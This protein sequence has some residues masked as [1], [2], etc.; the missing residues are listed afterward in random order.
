VRDYL[1]KN[2]GVP[3]MVRSDP[4]EWRIKFSDST[5]TYYK[6]GTLYSTPSNSADP[7]VL[8][9]WEYVDS[10]VG[11]RYALPTKDFLIGLDETGKGE[12][13]GHTVLTG[14]IFPK[15]IFHQV[16]FVVGS[17]DTKSRHEYNYWDSLFK[18]LDQFRSK[19]LDFITDKVAPWHVDKFNINKIM[20]VTYQ[21]ILSAFYRESQINRCRVVL[22]DYGVGQTLRR[23]LNFLGKQ[24][25]EII[26]TNRSDEKYLEA[27]TASLI[28]KW[29]RESVMKAISDNLEFK[30][31]ELSV[32]SGNAGD[33][34]TLEWLHR[35][36]QSGKEW[37]W[38][39][40][41]SFRT[42]REIEGKSGEIQKIA[43]PI[44]EE[45]L[46]REFITE[47]D[48]G[49]FSMQ[50]LSIVCPLCGQLSKAV[51]YAVSKVKC[52]SCHK[53]I[54]DVGVTLRYYCG[55]IVP[56]TNI[57]L[58]GL[59]SKDL[60]EGKFFEN[61]TVIIPPIVRKECETRGGRKECDRLAKFASMG[62]IKLEEPGTISE[63]PDGLSTIERDERIVD[64]VF[65]QNAILLTADNNM[66]ARAIA[67][68]ILTIF[69]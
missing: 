58:K 52:V 66:K 2:G 54:D 14:V 56:D 10:L 35:W 37:P 20:D 24:D 63:A 50:S 42:I 64:M 18:K 65:K 49:R 62:R 45:L 19:G 57:I 44:K 51:V 5:F 43:P 69:A 16:D 67:K 11:S 21:R 61:F 26:V 23:F 33:K 28:S 12:V 40:K 59:L 31:D 25:S 27:R 9:A 48:Q 60:E 6:K 55:Y 41:K 4:E 39:V 1:T 15:D 30:I 7:A 38:F 22:D 29:T 34:Q 3:D 68:K 47:L 53:F 46:S 17:A 36:R 13:I 32:G 8:K